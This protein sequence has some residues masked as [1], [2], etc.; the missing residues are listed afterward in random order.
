MAR[1]N[2]TSPAAASTISSR[3]Y[4]FDLLSPDYAAAMSAEA[5]RVLR[6]SGKLCLVLGTAHPDCPVS[7]RGSGNEFGSKPE[8]VGGCCPVDLRALLAA[9]GRRHFLNGA[10]PISALLC[11]C[12]VQAFERRTGCSRHFMGYRALV[13]GAACGYAHDRRGRVQFQNGR[14]Y[15]RGRLLYGALD[16]RSVT[17]SN[18]G[19]GSRCRRSNFD[20]P[21][22]GSQHGSVEKWTPVA[23][24]FFCLC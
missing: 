16:L 22:A 6:D 23:F 14:S 8:V 15:G 21:C 3:I 20:R 17:G 12:V 9:L 7:S 5:H 10:V 18:R 13:D 24:S 4:V 19:Q 11:S 1:L 2:C